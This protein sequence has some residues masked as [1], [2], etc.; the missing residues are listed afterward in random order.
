MALKKTT[1]LERKSF[2]KKSL[3]VCFVCVVVFCNSCSITK[4]QNQKT[5]YATENIKC[6][7]DVFAMDTYMSFTAYG[8]HAEEAVNAAEA[9]I[10]RLDTLWSVSSQEGEIYKLNKNGQQRISKDTKKLLTYASKIYKTTDGAFDITVY[11]LMDLWGFTS[12]KY[13]VP[14]TKEIQ[15]NLELVN[16]GQLMYDKEKE[17]LTLGTGQ[18]VDL[19]AIAKGFASARI[20]EIWKEKGVNSG[21]VSLGGNVQVLGKK[22]DG[23]MWNVGIKRPNRQE[24][25][26]IGT[27]SLENKAVITSG[28]YERYFENKGKIYH[29]IL[30]TKTGY[31]A[32][33]GLASVTIISGDG[34]LADGLSTALFVMGKEKAITYWKEYVKKFDMIL[35][36]EEGSVIV[37]E[38]VKNCFTS[39]EKVEVVER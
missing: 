24:E 33:K 19:G 13:R 16:Q 18:K 3:F 11:P 1:L 27:L 34:T 8:G 12:G 5:D 21:V 22:P 6:S 39:A 35:V 4:K 14:T 7:K 32:E 15:N 37:T 23:S 31:P 10:K 17:N 30:D 9:E 28:G 36:T 25:D 38:G 26:L 29:H 20:M 2:M